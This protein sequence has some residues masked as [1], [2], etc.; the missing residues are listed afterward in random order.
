MP[1]TRLTQP[2][3]VPYALL[4]SRLIA[5]STRSHRALIDRGGWPR[6]TN[7]STSNAMNMLC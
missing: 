4:K 3:L 1:S 6:G 7:D 5:A 2:T